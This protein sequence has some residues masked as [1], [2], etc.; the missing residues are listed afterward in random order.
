MSVGGE[1]A[2]ATYPRR[3]R[4]RAASAVLAAL[5]IAAAIA[6]GAV[7]TAKPG[8]TPTTTSSDPPSCRTLHPV[9]P[10]APKPTDGGNSPA[11]PDPHPP[12][13]GLGP[14]GEPVGGSRLL[15]RKLV[16][17]KGAPALPADLTARAFVLVDLDNGDILAARDPHGRFQPASI[18][19]LLTTITLLPLLPGAEQVSVSRQAAETEGSHAGL[20][21]GGAYTI[22]QIFRGLLLVSG[23]DAAEALAKAAGGRQKTVALMNA[24]AR[25]LGAYDTFIQTPSG[26]DGWQQLTSAYDMALF[27]RAAVDQPRLIAY[28]TVPRATLP[29]QLTDGF[30]AVALY[31]QNVQFLSTVKGALLAKTG[32]TDAAQ[33]TFAGAIKRNG[34]RY[35]VVLLRAQRYPDDQWVQARKLVDW[36]LMLPAGTAPV[37]HLDG[38]AGSQIAAAAGM[39]GGSPGATASSSPAPGNGTSA[40]SG[41]R[42]L[43]ALLLF[44]G[45]FL[46]ARRARRKPRN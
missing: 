42:V 11:A 13:G 29:A 27:L 44:G 2:A 18:Q 39:S 36:G 4:F 35:G 24:K 21:S 33:H 46:L 26:L 40:T 30:D 23:N 8:R 14:L 45:V 7:A 15:A 1:V 31:N 12:R 41:V 28:D 25:G 16:L 17:P 19:K 37:G 9:P 3:V 32:Y 38:A 5:V 34:H 6:P 10:Q 22:D 20:V 43:V